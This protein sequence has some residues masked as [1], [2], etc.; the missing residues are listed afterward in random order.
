MLAVFL[1]FTVWYFTPHDIFQLIVTSKIKN[2]RIK[3]NI[4]FLFAF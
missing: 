4:R 2:N 3:R 1:I